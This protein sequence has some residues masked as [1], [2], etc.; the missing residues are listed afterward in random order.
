MRRRRTTSIEIRF[1]AKVKKT[2][3]CWLWTASTNGE[4]YGHLGKGRA[5]EGTVAAHRF[6]WLLHHGSLPPRGIGILHKCD[7]PRCVRPSHLFRGDQNINMRDAA[8]KG[9]VPRG[10]RH[11]NAKLTPRKVAAI[12]RAFKRGDVSQTQLAKRF[13]VAQS[14][15]SIVARQRGW[16]STR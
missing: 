1:W 14:T 3:K 6:S 16:R 13:N 2:R 9:R 4:G 15:I 12:R 8:T 11:W 7:N 5:G 10:T